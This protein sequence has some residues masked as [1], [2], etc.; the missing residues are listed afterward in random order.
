[1]CIFNV[2][3]YLRTLKLVW[4]DAEELLIINNYL[5]QPKIQRIRGFDYSLDC[6]S[7]TISMGLLSN[8]LLYFLISFD[9]ANICFLTIQIQIQ[10]EA[11]LQACNTCWCYSRRNIWY[12]LFTHMWQS[13]NLDVYVFTFR[14]STTFPSRT[15]F[16]M[17]Q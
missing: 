2:K 8:Y 14:S 10:F 15:N 12:Q 11:S 7:F 6:S 1:M 3:S 16:N 9:D 5:V 13:S 4:N 17:F